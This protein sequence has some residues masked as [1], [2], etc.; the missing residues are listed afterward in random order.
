MR[1]TGAAD[2]PRSEA[3]PEL[4]EDV[5]RLR[6]LLI[7]TGRRRPLRDPI[8]GACEA[9]ELSPAQL[10]TLMWTGHDG[11]LTM[12]ELSRRVGITEKTITGVV[13]RL[14]DAGHLQRE[15]DTDDRRVVR[16]RL[17]ATGEA[18]FA[19]IDHRLTEHLTGLLGRLD[20]ADRTDLFRLLEK[21]LAPDQPC[22][23]STK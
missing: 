3:D 10:H 16:V 14:A 11:P 18:T 15:R 21:L 19:R 9:M 23:E 17:T 4:G 7:S 13:D 8:A 20:P 1:N 12:G 22:E 6:L 2:S 5:R